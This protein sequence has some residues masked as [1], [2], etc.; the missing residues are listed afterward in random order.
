VD[1]NGQP[2]GI[3]GILNIDT[4]GG[5]S[6]SG[7][8]L[9]INDGNFVS[10]AQPLAAS[11]V[12]AP[13]QFG[14]VVFQLYPQSSS[15]FS[16][17]YLAGYIVDANH[18]RLVES[19][20]D[21]F[22]GVMGG[23]AL[24]QGSNAGTFSDSSLAG[25]TYV[26]GAAGEDPN[27]SLQVAGVFT[28]GAGGIVTGRLNWNDLTLK[29]VQN[30][31]SFTGT[32]SVDPTGR[33]TLSKLTDGSSFTYQ[34]Q[35]YL[36]GSGEGLILSSDTADVIAGRG[37]QQQSGAFTAAAFN[38]TYGFDAAQVSTSFGALGPATALGPITVAAG[39]GT[40]T[41]TGFVDFGNGTADV[42]VSGSVTAAPNGVF[43]GTVSGLNLAAYTSPD[44]FVFYL[45]DNTR[46]VVIETD[47]RQLTLG[48]VEV[49]Q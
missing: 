32:Y 2:A 9:D 38:G 14:R 49:Q 39:N 35:L 10:G 4:A 5:I 21:S 18:I 30:P 34:L 43:T 22:Q 11:T 15:I 25:S 28:A 24:S 13:D 26:F 33:V 31:V 8:V 7:S 44:N 40:D 46:A 16:S 1:L 12:S 41:L 20:G 29:S 3:G 47:N 19:S 23:T 36:T 48:Y 6:G 42:A 17:L 27:G 45:I 37:L